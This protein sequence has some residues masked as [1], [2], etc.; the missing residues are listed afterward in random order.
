MAKT[1]DMGS[2]LNA[3]HHGFRVPTSLSLSTQFSVK[4]RVIASYYSLLRLFPC[5]RVCFGT[6]TL[7]HFVIDGNLTSQSSKLG[8]ET[9]RNYRN[10]HISTGHITR[11]PLC[12]SERESA[13][14]E[15]TLPSAGEL[16]LNPLIHEL[17]QIQNRLFP[18]R[19]RDIIATKKKKK[20]K[21]Q[22]NQANSFA[23]SSVPRIHLTLSIERREKKEKSTNDYHVGRLLPA[24]ALLAP[25]CRKSTTGT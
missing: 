8:S 3:I 4:L 24:G 11:I 1:H 23:C 17:G 2:C 22:A 9:P 15:L 25:W 21:T 10:K 12:T 19:L 20:K 14:P 13:R 7:S 18:S 6:Q 16:D 5:P